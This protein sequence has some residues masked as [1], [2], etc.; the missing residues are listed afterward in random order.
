MPY[1]KHKEKKI[2]NFY[3]KISLYYKLCYFKQK[4]CSYAFYHIIILLLTL[5]RNSGLYK[6]LFSYANIMK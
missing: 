5:T 6:I 4:V 2:H 1:S 3:E